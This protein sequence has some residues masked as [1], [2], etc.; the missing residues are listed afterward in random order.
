MDT[1]VDSAQAPEGG[2]VGVS[3]ATVPAAAG[4]LSAITSLQQPEQAELVGSAQPVAETYPSLA[5]EAAAP[6]ESMVPTASSVGA[7][8]A[9]AVPPPP[10]PQ[11]LAGW[12][13]SAR[14]SCFTDL[15]FHRF[16][17]SSR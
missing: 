7:P 17:V 12:Q 8:P 14:F 3:S 16:S 6:P 5:P 15:C 13:S 1:T 2:E 11:V 10:G 9:V 4:A